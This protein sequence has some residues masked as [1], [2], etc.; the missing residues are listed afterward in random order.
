MKRTFSSLSGVN[1]I[2]KFLKSIFIFILFGFFLFIA[3]F[4]Q[5]LRCS[6]VKYDSFN[7]LRP[8]VYVATT[9]SLQQQD[10]LKNYIKIAKK[11]IEDFWGTQQGEATIIFCDDLEKYR[12]YCRSSEGAGCTI[13]TPIG[14]WIV[15]NKDGLNADVIA[16]EMSHDELM[17]RLGWWKTK[18]KIPT[19][20]DEGLAL[21][22]DYRFV[23][24][25]DSAQRYKAYASE[26]F[27]FSKKA[28][29]LQRLNTE[30]EFFGQGELHTKLAYFTSASVISKKIAF[31]GKQAIFH[32]IERVKQDNVFEF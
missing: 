13:G 32:T 17:T 10:S 18:T 27:F 28:L 3:I 15:L 19:W 20:F 8:N 31:R 21:M 7:A 6:F 29:P 9:S 23:A 12:Q 11:R 22:L 30:K 4:P 1:K 2:M 5:V 26:L 14:S 16:H 24:T 25:Q